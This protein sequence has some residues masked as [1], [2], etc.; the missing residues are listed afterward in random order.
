[1]IPGTAWKYVGNFMKCRVTG[2]TYEKRQQFQR[3][4]A[5]RKHE[6]LTMIRHTP[7]NL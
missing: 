7:V 4:I 6:D 5:G 2:V 3:F 1:M